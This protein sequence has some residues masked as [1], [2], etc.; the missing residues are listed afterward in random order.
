MMIKNIL[1]LLII[2]FVQPVFILGLAYAFWN[3]SKRLKYVRKNYRLNFNPSSFEVTDYLFKS[4]VIGLILSVVVGVVGVPLTIEWYLI[5]QVVTIVLLLISGTRFIHPLFTFSLTSIATFILDWSGK[6]IPLDWL[7]N[8]VKQ[9]AV[10]VNFQVANPSAVI[11]N[12]LFFISMIL[13]F[14][15]HLMKK[16][17]RN[18]FYP[19][20]HSSERGKMVAKYQKRSILLLP[21]IIVVP[22]SVIEPIASWWPLF[23]IGGERYAL[24]LLPFLIGFHFT[25]STQILENAINSMKKD[26]YVLAGL[27]FLL[28]L[29]SYFYLELAVWFALILLIGG[30]FVLYRHRQRENMWTFKYGPAD[31]G[32]RIIAIRPNSPAERMGLAIGGIITHINDQEMNTKEEFYEMISYN[33]SYVKMRLKR[34]D[35]E[36]IMVETPLYDDDYNNLGL[37]I[38]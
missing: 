18:K 20:L 14:T 7:Q 10:A 26:L 28:T 22:G 12:S 21:L 32:L 38:L 24:L 16:R 19:I 31:E 36:I 25:I 37:L 2:F 9:E 5:Y 17:D 4:L 27:S 3:R 23:S 11:L 33:R 6:A 1:W 34:N 8:I 15:G 35:G 29:M 30:G 13:V